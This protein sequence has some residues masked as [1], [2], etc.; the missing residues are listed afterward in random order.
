MDAL[1]GSGEVGDDDGGGRR[2]RRRAARNIA[3]NAYTIDVGEEL[4]KSSL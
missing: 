1:G 2:P 3:R 4:G